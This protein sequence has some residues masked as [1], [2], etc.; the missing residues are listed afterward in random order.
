M[1][2][3]IPIGYVMN[4]FV[5]HQWDIPN[6]CLRPTSLKISISWASQGRWLGA[7]ETW[8]RRSTVGSGEPLRHQDHI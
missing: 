4:R 5:S 1:G 7:R 6:M 2:Q 3:A 8:Y